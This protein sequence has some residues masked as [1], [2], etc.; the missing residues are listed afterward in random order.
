MGRRLIRGGGRLDG[1]REVCG[2]QKEER[3]TQ[4]PTTSTAGNDN[5]N[6]NTN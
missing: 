2:R 1:A 6:D 3:E 4:R 5:T